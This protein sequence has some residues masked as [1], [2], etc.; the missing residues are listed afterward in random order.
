MVLSRWVKEQQLQVYF[1]WLS[2]AEDADIGG[3][4]EEELSR[5]GRGMEG[6]ESRIT[7]WADGM[8]VGMKTDD[9]PVDAPFACG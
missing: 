2:A 1:Q 6:E 5:N 4:I 7:L 3:G 9:E 8:S